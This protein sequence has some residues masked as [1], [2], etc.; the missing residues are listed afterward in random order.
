MENNQGSRR[1]PG[2]N[3][4][5]SSLKNHASGMGRTKPYPSQSNSAQKSRDEIRKEHVMRRRKQKKIRQ[6]TLTVFSLLF[7]VA[8]GVILSLTVFFNIEK[9]TVQGE[10]QYSSD[11]IIG[12][13]GI[14]T[15]DNLFLIDREKAVQRI[16][17]RLPY[18]GSAEIIN[19]L[20]G[21]IIIKV[22]KTGA[23]CAVVSADGYI[24]INENS[25]VLKTGVQQVADDLMVM[26]GG[27]VKTAEI[28]HTIVF[29]S[30]DTE[31]LITELM[32]SVEK[33]G[34]TNITKID[35]S[36]K[37][38]VKMMYKN[39]IEILIGSFS[40]IDK[41]IRFAVEVINRENERSPY[42][43]GTIDLQSISSDSKGKDK[44]YFRVK[45]EQAGEETSSGTDE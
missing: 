28:G 44:V 41:K 32:K 39:R 42:Q 35:V 33:H 9:I 16:Q 8:L 17:S 38:N 12:T 1:P 40:E 30:K 25:K 2:T 31:D 18:I 34:L 29:K 5:K 26:V 43:E 24:L 37:L 10:T 36:D 14:K 45:E 22:K 19:K 4:N 21:S 6:I 27:E 15:G 13:S 23:K 3:K 20:P 7:L 11:K